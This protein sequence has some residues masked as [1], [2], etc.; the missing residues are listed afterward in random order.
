PGVPAYEGVLL[1]TGGLLALVVVLVPF[2]LNVLALRWRRIFALAGLCFKEALRRRV[3]WAFSA[4]VLVFLFGSWFVASASKPEDQLR[5]Y[6]QLVYWAMTPLLLFTSVL[7]AAFSIPADIRQ[8]TIHTVLTK[9][10]QRFEVY[11]G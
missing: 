1:F 3:L 11:L 5:S 7:L 10:V 8:Q 6:V 4:L 2:L 9:P